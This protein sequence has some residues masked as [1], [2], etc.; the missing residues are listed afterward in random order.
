MS[1]YRQAEIFLDLAAGKRPA[2]VIV[3]MPSEDAAPPSIS[4]LR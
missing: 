2:P 3:T 4:E 1:L